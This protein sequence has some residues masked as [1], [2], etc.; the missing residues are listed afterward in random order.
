MTTKIIPAQI[1]AQMPHRSDFDIVELVSSL[2]GEAIR[3]QC[4]LMF[5]DEEHRPLPLIVPYADFDLD[6]PDDEIAKYG[7]LACGMART[8]G[9]ASILLTWERPGG[10]E[11]DDAER[12]LLSAVSGAIAVGGV[13]VRARLLSFSDG[14]R[15]LPEESS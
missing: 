15:L 5:L 12:S 9:A 8:T 13:P 14:V 11:L 2:V 1:A 7:A 4:W 6:P 3:R 10:S